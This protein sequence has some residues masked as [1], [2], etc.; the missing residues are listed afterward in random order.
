[1]TKPIIT[2]VNGRTV[3]DGSQLQRLI[4]DAKIGSPVSF[5]VIREGRQLDLKITI[6][7]TAGR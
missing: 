5:R 1:M 3:E 6:A 7:S 4:Q 2:A